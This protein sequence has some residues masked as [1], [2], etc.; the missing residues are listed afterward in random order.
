MAATDTAS[1][2]TAKLVPDIKVK[3]RQTFGIDSDMEVPAFSTPTEHVPDIDEA[4]RFDR[5][6][7]LAILAGFA[8]NRRVLIQGYHGTGKSTHIEQVAARLNWPCIRI[9]LDSHISRIDLV[10]RDAIV[11][12]NGV[13]VT[14]FREGLLPW[15]LQHPCALVFDEYDAGRA[16]VMF[17][18]QRVLEVEGKLTLLDQNRVIRPNPWFRLFATANTVGLGDTTG[19]Y[20]GTQT[21]NQGQMDRW[22]IVVALNYLPAE[23]E[24]KIVAA[25]SKADP[26]LIADM[27]RVAELTRQGFING[28]ISTVMSPRTV[29]T[30]AQNTEI[31][32]DPGF[33]FRLTFLNKCDE[34]E[35]MLVAEYYQRVFGVDLPESV[36]GKA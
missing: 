7:T 13:Q 36:V 22:N 24:Q 17:V 21:I 8:Y 14:E 10:G 5:D 34:A 9:N 31:F 2:D 30:W 3:V 4:Y 11:L 23:T 28:D 16:D 1:I 33:A 26:K 27:I 32:G 15:A 20:Q 29:I 18:I 12:K 35:R 25:K 6:T 19:L